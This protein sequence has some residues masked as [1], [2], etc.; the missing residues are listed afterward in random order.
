V[1]L[2]HLLSGNRNPIQTST[3]IGCWKMSPATSKARHAT[4]LGL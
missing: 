4:G 2:D 1:R 3:L